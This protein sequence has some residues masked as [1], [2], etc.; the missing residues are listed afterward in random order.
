MRNSVKMLALIL[1][2]SVSLRGIEGAR[3]NVV[4]AMAPADI[5]TDRPIAG[6]DNVTQLTGLVNN[7]KKTFKI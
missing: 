7:L 4:S 2:M 5:R 3:I 6:G 1:L